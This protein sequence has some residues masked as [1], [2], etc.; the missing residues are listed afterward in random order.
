MTSSPQKDLNQKEPLSLEA[1]F[2][3]HVLSLFGSLFDNRAAPYI[4]LIPPDD[5]EPE[6]DEEEEDAYEPPPPFSSSLCDYRLRTTYR[7]EVES[8]PA[9]IDELSARGETIVEG[10]SNAPTKIELGERLPSRNTAGKTTEQELKL[11][12][13]K[14]LEERKRVADERRRKYLEARKN[15]SLEL[16]HKEHQEY[17]ELMKE[18]EKMKKAE[19]KQRQQ[20]AQK[21]RD[22]M[23]KRREAQLRKRNAELR[24]QED[25]RIQFQKITYRSQIAANLS[26]RSNSQ[27]RDLTRSTTLRKDYGQ[28]INERNRQTIKPKQRVSERLLSP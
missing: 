24:K 7:Q 6:V 1:D 5:I 26:P 25:A 17:K 22:E 2:T 13:T 8:R 21:R 4:G 12:R 14:N 28:R 15:A 19:T 23:V 10:G 27:N 3:R 16:A 18:F 20:F 9:L 11:L